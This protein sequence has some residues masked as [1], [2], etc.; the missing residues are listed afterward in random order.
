VCTLQSTLGDA[1]N[2]GS[3]VVLDGF[4]HVGSVVHGLASQHWVVDL[5]SG[6]VVAEPAIGGQL[7]VVGDSVFVAGWSSPPGANPNVMSL[8]AYAADG[9]LQS[10]LLEVEN[11]IIHPVRGDGS[12]FFF[13]IDD[14]GSAGPLELWSWDL[15]SASGSVVADLDGT[16]PVLVREGIVWASDA[17]DDRTARFGWLSGRPAALVDIVD[18]P[19]LALAAASAADSLFVAPSYDSLYRVDPE[20]RTLVAL[21]ALGAGSPDVVADDRHVVAWRPQE[22]LESTSAEIIAIDTAG[23]DVETVATL[24]YEVRDLALTEDHLYLIAYGREL[25]PAWNALVRIPR[26]PA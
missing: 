11:A 12:A 22:P 16:W 9:T 25:A 21:A 4:A 10:T 19:G 2:P 7:A 15:E 24:D 1:T 23:G 6:R 14:L 18:L 5:E 13:V 20:Q 26:P 8:V 3:L 17:V